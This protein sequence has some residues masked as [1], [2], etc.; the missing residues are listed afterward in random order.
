MDIFET[1]YA[2]RNEEKAAPMAAYMKNRF[3]FLGIKTLERRI[4]AKPFL[5]ERNK[6]ESVDWAFVWKCYSFPE[7]E[8]QYLAMAYLDTVKKRLI[9]EDAV[10]LEKLIQAKSW[11]DT[12]DSIDAFVG[13]LV[14]Q[15]PELKKTLITKWIISE[16]I[17]LKRVSIIY[18][19]HYKDKTDTDM[20]SRAILLNTSTKEFFVD[21][22]IGWALR[23]YSKTNPDWVCGFIDNNAQTLSP[24]SIREASKYI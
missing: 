6:D 4:L 16:N 21:K 10:Q 14:L 24:L 3:A 15:Y 17:W 1:F 9:P 7:R 22:A 23:E 11:W 19:L 18:Q 20:L 8:F 12:V 2:A 13:E 5:K